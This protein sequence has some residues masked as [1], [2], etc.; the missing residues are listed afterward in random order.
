MAFSCQASELNRGLNFRYNPFVEAARHIMA[1]RKQTTDAINQP[2]NDGGLLRNVEAYGG[3]G[4]FH[5]FKILQ[6]AREDKDY[7]EFFFMPHFPYSITM[8]GLESRYSRIVPSRARGY[9]RS[10]PS[11]KAL[12]MNDLRAPGAP[13][14][15]IL[16]NLRGSRVFTA[17]NRRARPCRVG[18]SK[19][20]ARPGPLRSRRP[21]NRRKELIQS[22]LVTPAVIAA[23]VNPRLILELDSVIASKRLTANPI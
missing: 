20:S 16:N 6:K 5:G 18:H 23:I 21:D 13:K 15:L 9:S 14:W 1:E 8:P 22:V 2:A 7:F 17:S 12:S 19:K 10:V 4:V 11:C 3:S